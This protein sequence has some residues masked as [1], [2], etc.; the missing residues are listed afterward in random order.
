[1]IRRYYKLNMKEGK[2]GDN[3]SEAIR[4]FLKIN[5]CVGIGHDDDTRGCGRF[6]DIKSED[7]IL[8]KTNDTDFL[9]E[10]RGPRRDYLPSIAD[11]NFEWLVT[12]IEINIVAELSRSVLDIPGNQSTC[13]IID[14]KDQITRIKAQI[15][16]LLIDK[17]MN[18]L[19]LLLIENSQMVLTGPPGTGKTYL[20]RELAAIMLECQVDGLNDS[21]RFGFVQFHPAYD[22]TDFVEGLKP[23]LGEGGQINFVLKNGI[24]RDFCESASKS[25]Q[26]FVFVIDEIN[27]AD[28]SR[29]FG[30]LFYALEPDYR[31]VKGAVKT[32][33]SSLRESC[34]QKFYVPENVYIIG[35]MN[36]IDRSV[37]S[38]DFAL[39]RRF[40]WYEVKADEAHFDQVM[41]GLLEGKQLDSAKERY[42]AINAKIGTL[43]GLGEAY[44]VG[45]AYFR[46]LKNYS[47]AESGEIRWEDFWDYHLSPLVREYVRGM[48]DAGETL[49]NLEH[50]FFLNVAP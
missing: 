6:S 2:S 44:C 47:D 8:L 28:L 24:F 19:K 31:G 16:R 17:H 41:H 30:E 10:A 4:S 20:A 22:Y 35:T 43:A 12:S 40:A 23:S 48:A 13:C 14:D 7:I 3:N 18:Q 50:A 37:E 5:K 42:S 11:S 34:N 32:Q 38:M 15:N 29:V 21:P 9:L 39:R 26:T 25:D 49:Q 36:D 1:M 27:R 45:P 33:Y 46:K